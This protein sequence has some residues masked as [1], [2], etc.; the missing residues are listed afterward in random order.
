MEVY[1]FD[2]TPIN[3]RMNDKRSLRQHQEARAV[4]EKSP[5]GT[6]N[7]FT[8]TFLAS[9]S[10]PHRNPE[11][12]LRV[13]SPCKP[14]NVAYSFSLS[15]LFGGESLQRF[16]HVPVYLSSEFGQRSSFELGAEKLTLLVMK[17]LTGHVQPC[18]L[19]ATARKYTRVPLIR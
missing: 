3:E 2:H 17:Q 4:T 5:E 18:F 15:A 10:P 8:A 19:A 6:T 1:G 11:M 16:L 14:K 13:K 9:S 7:R 12:L